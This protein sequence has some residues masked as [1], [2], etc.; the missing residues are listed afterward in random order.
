MKLAIY[1]LGVLFVALPGVLLIMG[2][3]KF[4]RR[5][6]VT[7]GNFLIF[8]SVLVTISLISGTGN[9]FVAGYGT[10]EDLAAFALVNMWIEGSAKYIGILFVAIGL[11][12][13]KSHKIN[14]D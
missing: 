3:R 4:R 10:A 1:L 9:W 7:S 2:S 11:L 13:F 8:G 12:L 14:H 5:A 6:N